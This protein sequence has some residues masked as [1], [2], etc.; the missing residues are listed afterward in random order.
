[1]PKIIGQAEQQ[2]AFKEIGSLLKGLEKTN[3]FLDKENPSGQ[4]TISFTTEDG[5][6]YSAIALAE[7]KSVVDNLVLNNKA[8]VRKR[9]E[10]LAKEHRIGLDIDDKLVLDIQLTPE[11]LEIVEARELAKKEAENQGEQESSGDAYSTD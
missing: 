7:H 9:V 2:A 8:A 4:F 10:E 3:Q 5:T 6:K 1:M 11:E